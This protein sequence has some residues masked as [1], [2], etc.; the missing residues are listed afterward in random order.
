LKKQIAVL[1][2]A[3]SYQYRLPTQFDKPGQKGELI[4]GTLLHS[5]QWLS[6]R[7]GLILIGLSAADFIQ[8]DSILQK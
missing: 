6:A 7:S 8:D 2:F 3:V 4:A 5:S 1:D